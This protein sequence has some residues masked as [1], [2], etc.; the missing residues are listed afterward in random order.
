[1][2]ILQKFVDLD[3]SG[4]R[5]NVGVISDA[6]VDEYFNVQV[7]KISPEFPIPVMHSDIETSDNYPGGGA[8]VCFQFKHLNVNAHLISFVD[9]EAA[10]CFTQHGLNTSLCLEINNKIPRKKRFY[11]NNF[12]TYRWDVEQPNYGLSWGLC[13]TCFDLYSKVRPY[14]DIFDVL[15][16][17]DYDKGVLSYFTHL[18]MHE[19][20]IS[21]VDPKSK[22]IDRWKGCTVFKPNVSEALYLTGCSNIIDAG[23]NLL[24]RLNCKA[25]IVTDADNG[26]VVFDLDGM[27]EIRP[28][29]KLP[30]AESVIGAGDAY[31]SF[32]A[33]ALGR[34]MTI[35]E[36]AE[37]A[38][39]AGVLYVRNRHNKPIS[40]NNLLI[41]SSFGKI[42]P[43][44]PNLYLGEKN[45]RDYKLVFTNGCFDAGLTKGHVDC[46]NF[47][48]K[49]GD[50]LIVALN[51]DK[52][53]KKLKGESRPI[54]SI[55]ERLAIVAGLA[56]VDYV[57]SFDEDNPLR[58]IQE[59]LPSVIVK[60]GDYQEKDVVGYGIAEIKIF[61]F[62]NCISTTQ[63]I[64]KI[65]R[66]N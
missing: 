48:K 54:L 15:I 18:L 40:Y 47:A 53:V 35:R 23:K 52:S 55:D 49:Q 58:L 3:S 32:L 65:N 16:F 44:N 22:D 7:K 64:D 12:P 29:K 26:V 10:H 1:M 38:W 11:N 19:V 33:T 57:I 6:M 39:E 5:I 43:N 66:I 42:I 31:T 8:N 30:P 51:G 17:S 27:Y 14:I 41:N 59:I 24:K 63:K 28:D 60:G 9:V 46:L 56:C 37:V 4:K 45:N 62:V 34:G 61:D 2:N 20:R 13:Y 25:V 21:I 36:A 50:K